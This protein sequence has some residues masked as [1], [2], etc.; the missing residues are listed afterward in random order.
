MDSKLVAEEI[1][2]NGDV[3]TIIASSKQPESV[4]D[5]MAYNFEKLDRL[6]SVENGSFRLRPAHT[7]FLPSSCLTPPST[8]ITSLPCY[9]TTNWSVVYVYL[10]SIYALK[11]A[12]LLVTLDC[13]PSLPMQILF[14]CRWLAT[15]PCTSRSCKSLTVNKHMR[16]SR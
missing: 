1:A 13:P 8:G 11:G 16:R 2:S 12:I 6:S 15:L 5:I 7:L 9:R 14:R 3:V 10:C 4:I